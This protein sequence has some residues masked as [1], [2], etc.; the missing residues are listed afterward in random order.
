MLNGLHEKMWGIIDILDQFSI[1][2][3]VEELLHITDRIA[4]RLY[5]ISSSSVANPKTISMTIS[6]TAKKIG[7][8]IRRGLMSQFV[9]DC[10]SNVEAQKLPQVR[11]HFQPSNFKLP[12]EPNTECIM[13]ATGTGYAPFRAFSQEKDYCMTKNIPTNLGKLTLFFG[14][15]KREE[16]YIYFDEITVHNSTGV[17]SAVFD[18]FSREDPKHKVYVQ[19]ILEH[20][21]D[22][23]MRCLTS[24]GRI[25]VCGSVAMSKDVLRVL[26]KHISDFKKIGF[27]ESEKEIERLIEAKQICMEAW[28]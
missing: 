16:D 10:K 18:A 28:N 1:K 2:L 22:M 14:C 25:Y 13:I 6:L 9:V 3:K 8:D 17:Y 15:R 27:D 20:K 21:L 19:D 5:T 26:A 24:N 12:T 11:Y 23:L 7:D 4:P